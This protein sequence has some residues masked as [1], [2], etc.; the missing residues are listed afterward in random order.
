MAEIFWHHLEVKEVEKIQRTNIKEGLSE[1]EVRIRRKEFGFNQIPERKRLTKLTIFLNQ[2]K[3]LFIIILILAGLLIFFLGEKIDSLAIFL[4]VLLNATIGFFQEY[5][6]SK[7]FESLKKILKIEARVIREKREKI[8]NAKEL[9]PGD[10]VILNAGDKVPADGRIFESQNLKVN[11]MILTGEFLSSLKHAEVL[12]KETV[13]ADRENMVYMGTIVEEGKGKMIVTETGKNTE[14]GK[15]SEEIEEIEKKT[16]LQKKIRNL[17]I[18]IATIVGILTFIIFIFGIFKKLPLLLSL[19]TAV[20]LAVS[21]IPE[22][23]PVAITVI[24]ALGAQRIL[25]KKGLVRNLASI[26]TLGSTS[27]ILTDKTLTLTEGRMEVKEIFGEKNEVLKGALLTSDAFIENPQEPKEKWILRGRPMEKAILKK[28]I[29]EKLEKNQ[30]IKN[31]ILEIP[32]DSQ[33]KFSGIVLRKNENFLIYLSGAPERLLNISRNRENWERKVDELAKEGFRVLGVAKKEILFFENFEKELEEK[34]FEFLG[35]I[36][37]KD[38]LKKG[39]KKAIH[40]AIQAGASPIIVSG[41]HKF[42]VKKTAEELGLKIKEEEILEGQDLDRMSDEELAKILPKIKIFARTDPRQKLRICRLWQKM[43]KVVAMTG[44]GVNDAP[45]LRAA[46]IGIA[47]GSGT[48]VAKEAADLILLEDNF[49]VIEEAIREGRRV[50]D[51]ARKTILFMSAECFSEIILVFGAFLLNLPLP[52]LPIQILWKNFVEGSPQGLAFAF[53]PEEEN[54]MKRK[55]EDPKISILTQ[56]I[57]YLI[58]FAGI[59]TDIILLF[60]FV[61]LFKIYSLPLEKL[62][63]FSFAGLALG[64]F[65]Y[66]FSCKNIRKNIWE[67]N[68]FSNKVLNFAVFFGVL[69]L[70]GAIY[71]PF[72]QFLLKTVGLGKLEWGFLMI[73]GILNLIIF[74][75]VKYFLKKK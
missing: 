45:A 51:N 27:I 62:R 56:E 67:Y 6:A 21:A 23:L 63:T 40:I 3:S 8:I 57:K 12:P 70:I 14:I 35:C 73:F 58:L 13:L 75:I 2:F 69:L 42:T 31:K 24:L 65:F 22:G 52:I 72:F 60:M 30:L 54:I 44:D 50:L 10:I 1:E 26:E 39:A 71:L 17:S 38:P 7:I 68:P 15:I 61:I 19:E 47:V 46:D 48:E 74:E 16:P 41:D 28:A 37:F 20:A 49:E 9:V 55:P 33:K 11:E 43:G 59:F 29:E 4:V 64:S 66:A 25:T 18:L 53:E 34:N 32:F 5:K 36:T